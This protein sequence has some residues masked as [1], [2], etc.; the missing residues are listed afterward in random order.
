MAKRKAISKGTRFDIFR[1][2]KFTCQYCG[3]TPPL[4][5]LHVDHITPVAKGGDNDP[6]NLLTS[7]QECNLGKSAKDLAVVPETLSTQVAE[8][9]ERREQVERYNDFLME[10]REKQTEDIKELGRYW[11]AKFLKGCFIFAGPRIPSI[12]KFLSL[13]PKATIMDAMDS[14]HGRFPPYRDDDSRT[15]RYFCGICWNIIKKDE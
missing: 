1:R 15:F 5:I 6:L 13:I 11:H 9:R 14:A 3:R 2:D 12:K 4:V 7:C 10:L 8:Q